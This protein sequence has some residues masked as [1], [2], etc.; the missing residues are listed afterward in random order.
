[1]ILPVPHGRSSNLRGHAGFFQPGIRGHETDFIY[2]DAPG[3]GNRRFQLFGKLGRLGLSGGKRVDKF[4][5]FR[6]RHLLVEL[7]AGQPS[8][9]K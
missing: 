7:H 1:L 5:E 9:G 2:T 3:I 6:L 4:G 8:R